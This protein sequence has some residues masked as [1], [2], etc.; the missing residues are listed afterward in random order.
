[1]LI[2][3]RKD[4]QSMDYDIID[5]HEHFQLNRDEQNRL[6]TE[7]SLDIIK[8]HLQIYISKSGTWLYLNPDLI[9]SEEKIRLCT[10]CAKDPRLNEFSIA[11]GHDYG[12]YGKLPLLNEVCKNAISP[13]RIFG[14]SL[15]LNGRFALGHSICFRS[16]GPDVISSKM[17]PN[18]DID[19]I[20]QI[21]F[22]GSKY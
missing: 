7:Y 11:N 18:I 19:I 16:D 6:E 22:I 3:N 21:T 14:Q 20:P 13:V 9:V 2:G 15:T 4:T 8:N 5:I 17:L 10:S 12:R 1:M